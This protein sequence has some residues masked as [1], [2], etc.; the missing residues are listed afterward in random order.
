VSPAT[1]RLVLNE[2]REQGRIAV[3]GGGPG[4]RWRRL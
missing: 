1:I 4:A 2:L 3:D